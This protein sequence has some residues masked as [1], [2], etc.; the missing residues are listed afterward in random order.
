M[1]RPSRTERTWTASSASKKPGDTIQV[2]YKRAKEE[3][4]APIALVSSKSVQPDGPGANDVERTI[5][6]IQPAV[7]QKISAEDP[8]KQVEIKAGEIGGPS[9]GLMFT[10]EILNQLQPGDLTKGYRIAGTGTIDDKGNVGPIGGIQHKIIA[11]DKQRAEIFFCSEGYFD[12]WLG[13]SEQLFRRGAAGE[14]NSLPDEGRAGR[15]RR[16]RAQVFGGP[17]RKIG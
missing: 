10:L 11:A 5:L 17:A 16:R 2:T 4:T 3:Q 15:H 6:G 12:P 7:I 8:G 1:I 14:A 13:Y 9:A